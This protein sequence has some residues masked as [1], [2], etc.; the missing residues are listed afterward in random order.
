M[1]FRLHHFEG[2]ESRS[3]AVAIVISKRKRH[4]FTLIELLVVIAII[5]ALVALLLP[6]VQ[7]ARESA[8]RTQCRNNLKQLGLALHNYHDTHGVLPMGYH[9]PLGTGWTYHLLPHLDQTALYSSFTVGTPSTATTSIWRNGPPE[10]ALGVTVPVFRCPSSTSPSAVDNV[11]SIDRR[12]PCDYLGCASGVRTT[13]SGTSVNG[14]G[15]VDLDGA[16][17]RIS[18]VR[19][20]DVLD[21]TSN[22]IGVGETFYEGSEL[23]HWAIGS[24]DLGRNSTP[25]SGDASEFL[26]SLGVDLNRFD[27]GSGTDVLEI[28]FKSRHVGGCQFLL[29]DGSVRFL[30]E[31]IS[32]YNRQALGTRKA[33]DVI[34][35]Y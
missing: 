9:W 18:S 30:S 16:F 28:S 5:A 15:V 10:V 32:Q 7:Q 3:P 1:E 4:A 33:S 2:H 17:F 23:D 21:G 20:S 31:N 13:D 26:A 8:R 12:V 27:D 29:L 25:T 24:D 35:E 19:L 6:A 22:T 14:I 11:N 34:G